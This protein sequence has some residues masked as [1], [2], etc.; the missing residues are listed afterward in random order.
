MLEFTNIFLMHWIYIFGEID[1][2]Q[3]QSPSKSGPPR[4]L[5]IPK[6]NFSTA[7]SLPCGYLL[8]YLWDIVIILP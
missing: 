8:E 6:A 1:L 3:A 7:A 2:I 5:P 4:I